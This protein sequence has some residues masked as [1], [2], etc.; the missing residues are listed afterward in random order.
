[1]SH[2]RITVVEV[3][4]TTYEVWA[5]TEKDAIAIAEDPN[6]EHPSR[7]ECDQDIHPPKAVGVD[8][9]DRKFEC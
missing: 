4:S 8:V 7:H 2:Y 5:E 1:M 3:C 9:V 6:V